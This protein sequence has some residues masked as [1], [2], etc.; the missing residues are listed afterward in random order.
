[1]HSVVQ[2]LIL[3]FLL[4]SL[5]CFHSLFNTV[6]NYFHYNLYSLENFYAKG[7]NKPLLSL[8]ECLY[9]YVCVCLKFSVKF[10]SLSLWQ[11]NLCLSNVR[12]S[13]SDMH[14]FAFFRCLFYEK[15]NVFRNSCLFFSTYLNH[16]LVFLL[17]FLLIFLIKFNKKL[18]FCM[19]MY[20]C[21]CLG[22]CI[23]FCS[24]Y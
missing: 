23:Y 3:F 16:F 22:E 6:L 18:L 11:Y 7:C 15:Q 19:C 20:M 2:Y 12:Q 10:R 13:V 24:V 17:I 8:Y 1:M 4:S 21:M 9:V 5:F 14:F